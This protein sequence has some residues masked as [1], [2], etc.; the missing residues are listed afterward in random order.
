MRGA[1]GSISASTF[2]ASSSSSRPA[3][4]RRSPGGRSR[5][6]PAGSGTPRCGRGLGSRG[7]P[8][9]R[10]GMVLAE[11]LARCPTLELVPADPLGVERA[12]EGRRV[13]SKGSAR[14]SSSPGPASRTST[15]RR[16]A[17]CYGGVDGVIVATRRALG[18]RAHAD[19]RCADA[20]LR[21]RRRTSRRAR[22]AHACSSAGEARLLSRLP[23]GGPARLP[24]SDRAARGAPRAA[25]A[26]AR[27]GGSPRSTRAPSVRPLRQARP[28]RAHARA[29]ARRAA[30]ARGSLEEHPE[31]TL[32]LCGSSSREALESAL[33]LLLE[34][35]LARRERSGR[36][37]RAMRLSAR[38][39]ERGT[40]CERVVFREALAERKAMRLALGVRLDLLPAPAEALALAVEAFGPAEAGQAGAARM[41]SARRAFGGSA[42]GD[43]AVASARRGPP[44]RCGSRLRAPFAGP[45]A[46][47][48][49]HA[50]LVVS[51][52]ASPSL[53]R[54]VAS[55]GEHGGSRSSSSGER[56]QAVRESWLVEDGWWTERPLAPPLP[57]ARERS[58]P[59]PRRLPRPA[60]RRV[61]H[62]S[63]LKPVSTDARN[64]PV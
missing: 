52:N 8:G 20:L 51:V 28:A 5:I 44:R 35:L 15:P 58:R 17:R 63:R 24:G 55:A 31:E 14:S 61:V 38:L 47:L 12:W 6:A 1:Q 7:G 50:L 22:A 9:V 25:W 43:G 45:R 40:W 4:P 21:A 11:A 2:P 48:R 18:R 60:R 42:R 13:R 16:S 49:V 30:L 10:R 64:A 34:R 37:I 46:A 39:A 59:Q 32:E 54:P 53:P 56:V 62:T 41:Q 57:R 36:T 33:D 23:A 26:S 29:R 27:S 19:R 3:A